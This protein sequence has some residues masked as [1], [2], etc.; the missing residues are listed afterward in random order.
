MTERLI[1]IGGSAGSF[2][3]VSKLLANLPGDFPHPL[4]ICLHRLRNARSGFAEVLAI[5]SAINVVE[6]DDKS[7]ILNNTAYVAPANY[8]MMIDYGYRFAL[9]EWPGKSQ[10]AIH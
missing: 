2:K 7:L 6:P 1:I 9:S 3:I 5:N 10:P 4:I 8:H